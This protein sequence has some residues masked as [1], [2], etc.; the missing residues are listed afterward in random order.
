[1]SLE[2]AATNCTTPA[3]LPLDG[4]FAYNDLTGAKTVEACL[5]KSLY[6]WDK[7]C[8]PIPK[9][10]PGGAGAG[11]NHTG[12]SGRPSFT[13]NCTSCLLVGKKYSCEPSAC[14]CTSN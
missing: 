8:A 10:A 7:G 14:Q 13:C 2:L 3:A 9:P 4:Q 5:K 11:K 6:V 1:M 12:A